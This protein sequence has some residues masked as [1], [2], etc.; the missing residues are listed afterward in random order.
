[1]SDKL[2]SEKDAIALASLL[3]ARRKRSNPIY[4]ECMNEITR[5]EYYYCYEVRNE[6]RRRHGL[7]E[8][9]PMPF[10]M[11]GELGGLL[12]PLFALVAVGQLMQEGKIDFHNPKRGPNNEGLS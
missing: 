2:F 11:A 6:W 7:E 4:R 8:H 9:I 1:M 12:M 10:E 5:A 3:V